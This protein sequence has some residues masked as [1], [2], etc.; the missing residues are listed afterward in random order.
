MSQQPVTVARDSRLVITDAD[1]R[2]LANRTAQ[3]SAALSTHT[4]DTRTIAPSSS[5]T[6][7]LGGAASVKLVHIESSSPLTVALNGGAAWTMT[8]MASAIPAVCHLEGTF[9]AIVIANPNATTSAVLT[10]VTAS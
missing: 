1:G 4:S 3:A 10:C 6:V 2:V 8:P 9:T 7:D 5:W